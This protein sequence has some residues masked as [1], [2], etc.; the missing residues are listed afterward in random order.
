[1]NTDIQILKIKTWKKKPHEVKFM[2]L[3]KLNGIILNQMLI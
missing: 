3:L 2:G 1:M